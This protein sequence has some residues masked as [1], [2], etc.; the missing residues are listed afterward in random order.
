MVDP[1][2]PPPCSTEGLT[3][4]QI[5][6]LGEAWGMARATFASIEHATDRLQVSVDE[7]TAAKLQCLAKHR[8]LGVEVRMLASE[9]L[10][11]R[12]GEKGGVS[13]R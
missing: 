8:E 2:Q 6:Q 4:E 1:T 5:F 3:P 12:P 10:F 9:V 13:S 11:E 7:T